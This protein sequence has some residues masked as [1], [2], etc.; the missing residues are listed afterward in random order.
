LMLAGRSEELTARAFFSGLAQAEGVA[1]DGLSVL[2]RAMG[3]DEEELKKYEPNAGCQAYPA[4]LSWLARNMAPPDAIVEVV[5]N[6]S[7]WGEYCAKIA[8]AMRKQYGFSDEECAF[9][10]FFAEPDPGGEEQA[11]V[12]VQAALDAGECNPKKAHTYGRLFQVYELMFW[13]TLADQA[14]SVGS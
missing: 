14:T 4:F 11:I 8:V 5:A 1:L 3:L 9:F 7:A 13:N 6:C 12:A 2:A 10:D